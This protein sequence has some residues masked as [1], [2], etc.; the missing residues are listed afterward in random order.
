MPQQSLII[1]FKTA[2]SPVSSVSS[3]ALYNASSTQFKA[4]I[5]FP[6]PGRISKPCHSA[7]AQLPSITSVCCATYLLA[8]RAA[9]TLPANGAFKMQCS[10]SPQGLCTALEPLLHLC[11]QVC[12]S[13]LQLVI[14]HYVACLV[15]IFPLMNASRSQGMDPFGSPFIPRAQD[16]AWQRAGS[17]CLL[18]DQECPVSSN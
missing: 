7:Q 15:S 10:F 2:K 9:P 5:D 3:L 13:P 6:S 14:L 16:S 1:P 11:A 8:P 12:P 18:N 4:F 17:K